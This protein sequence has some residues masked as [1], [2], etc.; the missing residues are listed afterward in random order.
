MI[1]L[2]ISNATRRLAESQ[3]EFTAL[4]IRD[5][6]IDGV[7]YM[8]SLWE[9]SPKE[10]EQLAKGGSIRLSIIGEDVGGS[11]FRPVLIEV[12]PYDEPEQSDG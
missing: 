6:R 4:S 1:S 8:T 12:Q 11:H 7:N 3:D 5:E 2:R 10:L 9:P